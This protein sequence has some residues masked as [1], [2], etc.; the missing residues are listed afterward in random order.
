MAEWNVDLAVSGPIDL[1]R[2]TIRLN[3][4]K[5]ETDPF[6]TDVTVKRHKN[7]VLLTVLVH[8]DTKESAHDAALYFVGRAIDVLCLHLSLIHISEPTRP[9]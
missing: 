3:P 9:Y 4:M 5:G 7:G 6:Q 1:P 2:P 8:A